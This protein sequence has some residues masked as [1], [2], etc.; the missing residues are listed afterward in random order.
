MI[1][2]SGRPQRLPRQTAQRLPLV[3]ARI[4]PLKMQGYWRLRH[5]PC[6]N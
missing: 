1:G 3:V 5:G 6:G 4:T 2:L